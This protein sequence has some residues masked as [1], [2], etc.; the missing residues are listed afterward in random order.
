MTAVTRPSGAST[1]PHGLTFPAGF[2]WGAATAAYQIE[3]S[4]TVD[5]RGPSI[6]DTFAAKP[7]AILNGDTGEQACD[8]FRRYADDVRLMAE[9]GLPCYRFSV[10]WPRVQP[11]GRTTSAA[12]LGFY[13][14]LVDQLLEHGIEPIATL[15]HWDLPQAL[16]DE[17]GWPARDTALRFAD[18]AE[19]VYRVLGDRVTDWTT[20]NE[21]FCSAYFGYGTGIHAPG[22]RDEAAALRAAHHLLLAHGLGTRS[23][24]AAATGP[25]RVSIVFNL[26][27]ILIARDD[28]EHREA[29][30][31]VDGMQN[32]LFLDPVLGAGYP[33]D[34]LADIAFLDA[35]EP[36]IQDG[37]LDVIAT[38]IDHLGVNY[39][40]PTRYAPS[41]DPTARGT[42]DL[43]GVRGV[44]TLPPRGRLTGFGWEQ[45]PDAL[46]DLLLS[47]SE[48][49]DVPLIVAEN[50]AS[51]AD[52]VIGDR[53]HDAERTR[54]LAEHIRAVHRALQLGADVRGYLV[55]SLLDN[56][57][58]AMGFSQRFG[59][60]HVDFATQRRRVKDSGWM[61]SEVARS[62]ML[63]ASVADPDPG[64]YRR[65]P[66][67]DRERWGLVALG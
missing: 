45:D 3:G 8:H 29:A 47:V 52:E 46:T 12:G 62:N 27:S 66:V 2:R 17:G 64:T 10:A 60:V 37:D 5:G 26:G 31:K 7:G 67:V 50:G 24:R 34:V 44:D 13:D 35:L 63:P 42:C 11:D 56:F 20:I 41:G 57:E 21:P 54:Y 38:P 15:Y 48:R 25:L 14:R 16:Q 61:F 18:Y 53:V 19:A 55:W 65:R 43:P 28:P 4:T 58:W 33:P 49:C 36:A 6:W 22:I 30:R 1:S 23:L 59:I 39:Y 51:F 9:L 32:R 40:G